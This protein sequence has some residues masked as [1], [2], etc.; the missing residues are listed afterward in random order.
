GAE[1][2]RWELALAGARG[3]VAGLRTSLARLDR[4]AAA[5]GVDLATAE[6][7]APDLER[8][9][10]LVEA[11][12]PDLKRW[13]GLV[14]DARSRVAALRAQLGRLDRPEPA[15]VVEQD[16][17][18]PVLAEH[19]RLAGTAGAEH[20]G[21]SRRLAQDRALLAARRAE[22]ARFDDPRPFTAAE[23]GSL[24]RSVDDLDRMQAVTA[25]QIQVAR[26]RL[27]SSKAAI[28]ALR[29]RIQSREG[30]DG[31][32]LDKELGDAIRS[33]VALAGDADPDAKRWRAKAA[34]F[35]RLRELLAPLDQVAP[36]PDRAEALVA[37]YQ[38]LVGEDEDVRRWRDRIATVRELRTLLAGVD[39]V[40]PLPAGAAT[41]AVRL[42]TLVGDADID[43]RRWDARIRR[44]ETL[45]AGLDAALARPVAWV[46]PPVELAQ[47]GRAARE[48]ESLVG[49]DDEQ[50]DALLIRTALLEGPAAPPW[51]A[52]YGR[53]GFGLYATVLVNGQ[54]L[55]FRYVPAGPVTVG[56]P[57][58]ESGRDAD[59]APVAMT[60]SRPF[61]LAETETTQALWRAVGRPDPSR[62]RGE[63]R[64]VERVS[65]SDT[66]D[67]L[68]DLNRQVPGLQARLPAEI[69]W[70]LAA[71]A[72]GAGPWHGHQGPV[73][74][75]HLGDVAWFEANA[76]DGTRGVGGK[77]P[78]RLGLL[79]MHGNV[80]EW[81]QDTYGPYSSAITTD[82]VGRGGE[83][84]VL[85]G[86]SFADRPAVL[87]A[88]NRLGADPGLRTLY[89]GFRIAAPV[90]WPDARGPAVLRTVQRGLVQA[91]TAATGQPP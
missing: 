55:R 52:E 14:A 44:V 77:F 18:A 16:A 28:E 15:T 65:W 56:S 73:D 39:R 3:A 27:E 38:A 50:V 59:E 81:C 78:N 47:A 37:E 72:G 53:D 22:F 68:L 87:R 58:A 8:L 91:A 57:D 35:F 88:A 89:A 9:R 69:E 31:F 19:G 42:L 83:R 1:V 66:Q 13:A 49:R 75:G 45:T 67:F 24:G 48:L 46:L 64:P 51:A 2:Q 82:W 76:G 20:Q 40:A 80:W 41:A 60:V 43:A 12:D 25:V 61:W 74:A 26:Q 63:D 7:L 17:L 11:D 90:A 21:W 6:A 33:F 4:A 32:R 79:D 86:G 54:R 85:R 5:A 62:F 29:A 10:G 84:R 36:V 70:E 23:I 34:E 71:R 30:A